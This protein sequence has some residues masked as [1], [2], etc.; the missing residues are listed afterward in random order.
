MLVRTD[1][2]SII[3]RLYQEGS[4]VCACEKS[5]WFIRDYGLAR[6]AESP[7]RGA[8]S[9]ADLRRAGFPGSG[10]I[11]GFCAIG[12]CGCEDATRSNF[13]DSQLI[14]A[15]AGCEGSS[16]R[17]SDLLPLRRR[18]WSVVDVPISSPSTDASDDWQSSAAR[19]LRFGFLNELSA[20][21]GWFLVRG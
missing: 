20:S 10:E 2:S 4:G 17:N 3:K 9:V 8:H 12:I 5:S 16:G 7:F 1:E 21:F 11:A 18:P 15:R 6:R 13:L 14:G 19:R